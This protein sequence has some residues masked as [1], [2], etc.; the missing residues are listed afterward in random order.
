MYYGLNFMIGGISTCLKVS[1][2]TAYFVILCIYMIAFI[3]CYLLHQKK[4]FTTF[5]T[6][7]FQI[8]EKLYRF[9]AFFDTGCQLSYKGKPVIVLNKKSNFNFYTEDFLIINSGTGQ[10]LVKCYLLHNVTINH[11]KCSCYCVFLDI[12]YEAIIGFNAL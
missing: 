10:R 7:T 4:S 3:G 9:N 8:G 12:N 2:N 1:G 11:K 5:Y 6:I